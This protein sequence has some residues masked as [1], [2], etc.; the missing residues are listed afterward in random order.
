MSRINV[1]KYES[2][3]GALGNVLS[4]YNFALFMPF[5]HV[6]S[7]EFFPLENAACREVL[8]LFAMSI[9]LFTRP[10][11]AA[12]FGPIGDK[13]GRRKAISISV[14]LMA[15]PT[16]GIGLLPNY[17]KI[18]IL[19]P[20]LL[21]LLRAMQ[22]ISLGGEY[23]AAMV[24][25]V[26]CAPSN[27]RGF[28]GSLS[29]AGSQ[30]GVL[31]SGQ[32]LVLLY[33][34]FSQNEIYSFAWRIPFLFGIILLPFVF[35]IPGNAQPQNKEKPK[36]SVFRALRMYKKEVLCTIS[37]TSFSAVGFYTLLTFLPYYLVSN[38]MLSLKEATTCSVYS[39]LVMIIFIL[40]GG[41][42][43]DSCSRKKLM[44]FGIVG[45]TMAIYAMFLLNIRSFQ[46]WIILQMVYGACIGVYYSGRSVF[47][48]DA[49]PPHIRCTAVSLSLSLAQAIFG[50]MISI[51]M[52]QLTKIS[53]FLSII[54]ITCVS[55][56]ALI[57][58][59]V[60]KEKD[61]VTVHQGADAQN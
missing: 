23:A 43:S 26:E 5:L 33:A 25:L 53:L 4:W 15:I 29:D 30:V 27:R 55:C 39:T 54:P 1:E 35:L 34:F 58:L 36:E 12:I 9:G 32:A 10:L 18:G 56:F 31:I 17:E 2:C 14:L 44:R 57:A 21:I 48:S 61:S 22:G 20:I 16:V 24:H 47:F 40:I 7:S 45:V 13:F 11:G 52:A 42:F 60:L 6:I 49:F 50:G 37:I 28:Y 51:V 46:G 41:Y 59:T 38:D 3:V 19:S 8:S